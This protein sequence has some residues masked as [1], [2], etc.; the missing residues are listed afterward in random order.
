MGKKNK[1]NKYNYDKI[2]EIVD[3]VINENKLKGETK[4]ETTK[5]KEELNL[6]SSNILHS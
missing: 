1:K 4:E 5:N 6:I 2:K 3:K